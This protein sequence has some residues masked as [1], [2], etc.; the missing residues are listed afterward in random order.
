MLNVE[1][2]TETHFYNIIIKI[3][4]KLEGNVHGPAIYPQS[5]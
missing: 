5:K 1:V 4:Q 3:L 2:L